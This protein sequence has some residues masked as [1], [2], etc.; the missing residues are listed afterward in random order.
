MEKAYI[1]RFAPLAIKEMRRVGI[2]ASIT[3][4]QA[5][6]ES[7]AGQ[8][9]LAQKSNNHFGIKCKSYWTGL[10]VQYKD[11]DF[12]AKGKLIESC[13]RAYGDIESSFRDHSDFLKGSDKYSELFT[14]DKSDYKAWAVGLMSSGYATDKTYALKL[15]TVIE[16]FQ[17][18]RF[19]TYQVGEFDLPAVNPVGFR[20]VAPLAETT[21]E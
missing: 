12:D 10:T 8:S 5:V 11:D 14:L 21:V 6:V 4:A 1:E 17:L 16:D 3:L 18:Y 19:D 9:K 13:F 2:P 7:N 20:V 15:I